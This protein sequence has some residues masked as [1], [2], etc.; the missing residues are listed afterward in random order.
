[1]TSIPQQPGLLACFPLFD[2]KQRSNHRLQRKCHDATLRRKTNPSAPTHPPTGPH[3][4][5]PALASMKLLEMLRSSSSERWSPRKK[6]HD[7]PSKEDHQPPATPN[8]QMPLPSTAS[9]GAMRQQQQHIP[10]PLRRLSVPP[11]PLPSLF[12]PGQAS[13]I[14]NRK[15]LHEVR[16]E[17]SRLPIHPF[18][19]RFRANQRTHACFFTYQNTAG[20]VV[21]GHVPRLFLGSPLFVSRGGGTRG[22]QGRGRG[23]GVVLLFAC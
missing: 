20:L 22:C 5:A 21:A 11:A 8:T 7:N 6:D 19:S 3:A 13:E 4:N 16:I 14:L 15:D 17:S 9:S 2:Q 23:G 10:S 12:A 18:P 1:M